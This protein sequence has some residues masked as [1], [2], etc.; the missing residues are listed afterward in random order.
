M[1]DFDLTE[2]KQNLGNSLTQRVPVQQHLPKSYG[3]V[4]KSSFLLLSKYALG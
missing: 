2:F 3:S 4:V 1:I